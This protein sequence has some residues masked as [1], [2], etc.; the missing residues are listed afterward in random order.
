MMEEYAGAAEPGSGG[1]IEA[2][3][4]ASDPSWGPAFELKYPLTRVEADFIEEW[5]REKLTPDP[6]GVEGAYQITS[7]YYDTPRL[8]VFYRSP[9]YRR[10][11]FRLRRYG[12]APHA[13]LE[14]K[15][16]RGDRV[17][18]K[19]TA[20]LVEELNRL[21]D[22]VAG[23]A[24]DG[25]W[26]LEDLQQRDLQPSCRVA[27]RRTAFVGKL[28][29]GP[30]RLTLDRDLRGTRVDAWDTSVSEM[31]QLLLP[32]AVLLELKFHVHVPVLFQELLPRLPHQAARMS[33]YRRCVQLCRL[34]ES[35]QRCSSD[36][37]A[38]PPA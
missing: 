17:R 35:S 36:E 21:A 1:E 33:K 11:K 9:G 2:P 3:G 23:P 8:D 37:G 25:A 30:I 26:F 28:A 29:D 27:Y 4:L 19:R 18:K 22:P 14:R 31:G 16:R 20:V 32:E 10:R 7:L 15:W 6:H 38:E 12:Q 34:E 24:W 13:Y 5:A